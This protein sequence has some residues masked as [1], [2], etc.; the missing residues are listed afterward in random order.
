MPNSYFLYREEF[1]PTSYSLPLTLGWSRDGRDSAIAHRGASSASTG[2][3]SALGDVRY[4]RTNL[5]YQQY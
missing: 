1:G 2:E 5:Q 3:I 4:L